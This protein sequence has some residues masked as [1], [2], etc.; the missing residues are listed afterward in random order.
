MLFIWW[1]KENLS[2]YEPMGTYCTLR[3]MWSQLN[4][5]TA[6]GKSGSATVWDGLSLIF[7]VYKKQASLICCV[8][9]TREQILSAAE[10]LGGLQKVSK[11]TRIDSTFLQKTSASNLKT[12][13]GGGHST[14]YMSWA[15]PVALADR[16]GFWGILLLLLPT[17]GISMWPWRPLFSLLWERLQSCARITR[18]DTVSL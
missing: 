7:L 2:K 18:K 6:W 1:S 4:V 9:N 11:S 13:H 16:W 12:L 5:S 14:A 17:S 8:Y 15:I 10:C 3:A